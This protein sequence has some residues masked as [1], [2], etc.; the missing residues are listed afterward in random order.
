MSVY[1]KVSRAQLCAWLKGYALGELQ[2]LQGIAAGIENTNYF[3]TTTQGDYVLTLFEKLQPEELPF[4]LGLMT[5]LAQRGIPCPMPTPARNGEVLG[6]LCGK[7]AA[8]V[9][10]LS[11]HDVETPDA[12]QCAAVGTMLARMHLAGMD[13]PNTMPNPRGLTWCRGAALEVTPYIP[14][15]DA[16]LLAEELRFQALSRLE[17]MPRSAIHADL[18]R[19]NVLFDGKAIT[20]VIDFY[21]ACT[22]VALYDLAIA[23]NDWCTD[24]TGV[25]DETRTAALLTAYRALRT[26]SAS[27]RAAWPILLRAAALRF[28]V[29]RLY[30]LHCPRPGELTFAK[31]PGHFRRILEARIGEHSH[32]QL[33]LA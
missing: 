10:R 32:A 21:F 29:S 12:L 14:A 26:I 3:V 33:T 7:P 11:G 25:L 24:E 6:E 22:D 30:D 8:L 28:W 19:D 16:V 31:D 4:Y 27:E 1:T 23:V 13:Y 2:D 18:F 9:T 17:A 5:H 20:G 15:L